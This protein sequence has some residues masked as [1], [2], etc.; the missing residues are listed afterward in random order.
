[1]NNFLGIDVGTTGLKVALLAESGQLIG[2]EC[3]EYPIHSPLPGYA[4]QDPEAWW[5]GFI[6]G[7]S[8]LK[9]KYPADFE[10]I[11]GVGICGQMHT[12]VYL[13][14]E[15]Q[16]LRPAIT[17]MDQRSSDIV[18]RINHDDV[19]RELIFQETR[20]FATT[21]YTAPH[22]AWVKQH[23]PEVW[24]R[25]ARVLVAKDFIKF[26]LTGHM[27]TDYSEPAAPFCST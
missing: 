19:S 7:C 2:S 24:S 25:L 12:Q 17:W 14:R 5:R 15:N 13:D 20:N 16:I 4:E 22:L 8:D 1:M 11:A 21:T 26:R 6:A 10:N 23:Q 27:A 18:D 3:Y 9:S